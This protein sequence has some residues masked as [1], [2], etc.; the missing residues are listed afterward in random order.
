MLSPLSIGGLP[1][2]CRK[3]RSIG[4]RRGKP[5]A[6]VDRRE[7]KPVGDVSKPVGDVRYERERVGKRKGEGEKSGEGERQIHFLVILRQ[8][9]QML[10]KCLMI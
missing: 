3:I 9:L 7:G 6:E 10:N 8:I 2:A 1:G 4:E 5:K